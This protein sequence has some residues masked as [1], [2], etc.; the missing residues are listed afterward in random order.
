LGVH[1]ERFKKALDKLAPEDLSGRDELI[2]QHAKQ[3][4]I[5]VKMVGIAKIQRAFRV[6]YNR[7]NDI[8]VRMEAEGLITPPTASGGREVIFK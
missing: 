8:V 3:F 6:G 2:Y 4:V 5:E 1:Y 7:A